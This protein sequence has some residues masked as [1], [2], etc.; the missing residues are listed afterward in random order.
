MSYN[1]PPLGRL[2]NFFSP[3]KIALGVDAAKTVGTEAKSLGAAKALIVTDPGVV[4]AGLVEGIRQSL[5]AQ[6]I[7]VGLYDK[8][9]FETPAR[10]IDEGATLARTGGF[11]L[12][13]G[14]GGGTTLDTAKGV[15]LLATNK[16]SVLD[17]VGME[18][19]PAKALPKIQIP[20][21]GGSGSEITRVFALTDEGAKTKTIVYSFYNLAEVVILD[22]A[23]TVS[24]PPSLT[25]DTG[26]D[27]LGHAIE[28][29][30]SVN[31]TP[32]S[33]FLALE[34]IRL[35]SEN[36]L[37]AYA[38]GENMAARYTMLLAASLA[39]L[40]WASGGLGAAHAL[41]YTLETEHQI[42]HARAIAVI[43]PYVM[44]FNK[45]GNLEKFGRIASAMGEA[46]EKMSAREAADRAV[47]A[48]K[49]LL[50]ALNI[51]IKLSGYGVSAQHVD[52]LVEGAM[53]Q[54]R[55]FVPNPRNLTEDDVR[56]LYV[57]AL[58]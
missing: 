51:S 14:L 56:M 24:L 7:E 31:G 50:D 30:V 41:S 33:D 21:T 47:T 20:T 13:V 15:A 5:L 48:V 11:Q 9:E 3:S 12:I 32:F 4:K 57:R 52:R 28:A 58:G 8:V 19:A 35:V 23:L 38:K 55:L 16:G 2:S 22:P 40:A 39:G 43:L 37:A 42:G 45:I 29:Y 25:A 44:E 27:A 1:T 36:L 54:A 53:K 34:A 49:K 26:M 17:Y 18:L 6:N 10:V 46:T